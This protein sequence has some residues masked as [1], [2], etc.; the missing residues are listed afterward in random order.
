[1]DAVDYALRKEAFIG[2][3]DECGDTGV[4]REYEDKLLLAL[5]D[6]LGHGAKAHRAAVLV[7]EYLE[8]HYRES[9][10]SLLLGLHDNLKG[11]VGAVAG[12]GRFHRDT[13][14]FSYCGIGNILVRLYGSFG[15][16]FVSRDGVLGFNM[17]S[18]RTETVLLERGD[19]LVFTS[20]GLSSHISRDGY[21]NLLRGTAGEIADRF[22]EKFRRED[23]ASCLV[24]RYMPW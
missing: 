22:M 6:G 13:G 19:I 18:P 24:L 16:T 9:L 20:D 5:V 21:Q 1:M 14:E 8:E 4:I 11:S 23:D 10:E 15:R 17:P 3:D 7:E 12:I 2:G